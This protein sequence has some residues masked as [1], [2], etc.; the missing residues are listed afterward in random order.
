MLFAESSRMYPTAQAPA[1]SASCAA[2]S[3]SASPQTTPGS[4]L[5][6]E[7]SPRPQ[8][9]LHLSQLSSHPVLV[10]GTS[11]F[12]SHLA[13]PRDHPEGS[14]S[15]QKPTESSNPAE[16]ANAAPPSMPF[17]IPVTQ[18]KPRQLIQQS[19]NG[20]VAKRE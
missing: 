12:P 4:V 15:Y 5:A 7:E 1:P 2:P 14:S 10:T 13:P 20:P 18:A 6:L 19:L 16:A 17:N 11:C 3:T 9:D 8:E